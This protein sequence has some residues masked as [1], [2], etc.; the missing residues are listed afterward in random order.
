M[1]KILA[2]NIYF[3]SSTKAIILPFYIIKILILASVSINR[4]IISKTLKT[5]DCL[6]K[7]TFTILNSFKNKLII[8]L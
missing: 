7:K 6:S 4:L 5:Y 3:S 1:L 2:L 8:K